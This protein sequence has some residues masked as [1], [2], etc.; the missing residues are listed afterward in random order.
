MALGVCVAGA[1]VSVSGQAPAAPPAKKPAMAGGVPRL[2]DGHPDLQGTYDLGTLTPLERAAGSPLILSNE[3]AAKREKQTADR[4]DKLAA[5]V[6]ANRAAPPAGGDGSPGPYG[7][8]G[9]Y[10]NFWLD[11]GSRYTSIDGQKRASLL[12]DPPDGRGRSPNLRASAAPPTRTMRGPHPTLPLARTIPAS[13]VPRPTTIPRF[14]RSPSAALSASA[15]RLVRR[16][17]RRI[18]TTTSIRSCR[19]PIPC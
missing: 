3:E 5:P 18:S 2:A 16:F 9:G 8:V 10:N 6:D 17:C 13:K 1:G 19:R 11:P 15:R 4:N 7:N 12:I 14:V